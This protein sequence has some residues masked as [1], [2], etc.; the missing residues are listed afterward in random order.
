MRLFCWS[1]IASGSFAGPIASVHFIC[2][3]RRVAAAEFCH[4][5]PYYPSRL[6]D[7]QSNSGLFL[8]D[9]PRIAQKCKVYPSRLCSR[10]S[11][12]ADLRLDHPNPSLLGV[13]WNDRVVPDHEATAQA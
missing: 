6:P 11:S 13:F 7:D 3:H 2:L 10:R 5:R 12:D 8:Q 4:P 9:G 1:S